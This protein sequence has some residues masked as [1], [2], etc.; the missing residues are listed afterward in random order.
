MGEFLW[1]NCFAVCRSSAQRLCGGVNG[2]LSFKRAYATGCVTQ[3]VAS[4]ALVMACASEGD[5]NTGLAQS[6][7]GL[8][9]LVCTRFCLSPPGISGG[10]RAWLQTWF[11]PFYH[12]AGA[13]LC[14]WMR[15]IFSWSDTTFSCQWLFSSKLWFW[16]SHGRRWAHVLLLCHLACHS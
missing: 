10:Y 6:L 16:S 12:L 9:I 13:F 2:D 4:R 7:W 3:V 11:H 14:P 5:S 15:G 8:C 1:Y